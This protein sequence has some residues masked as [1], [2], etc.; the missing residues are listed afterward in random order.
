MKDAFERVKT[1]KNE[2]DAVSFFLQTRKYP[3]LKQLSSTLARDPEGTSRIPRETFQQVFD[4]METDLKG[5]LFPW[6]TIVEYFTKRGK[7][8]TRDEIK[9]LQEED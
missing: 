6:S 8:L 5:K 9:Y 4:R 1:K 2:C 7:P 3:P